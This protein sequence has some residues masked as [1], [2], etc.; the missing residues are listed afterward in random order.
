MFDMHAA[1]RLKESYSAWWKVYDTKTDEPTRQAAREESRLFEMALE[2]VPRFRQSLIH[3]DFS[4][5]E[6][7]KTGLA[8]VNLLVNTV[9]EVIELKFR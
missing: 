5:R 6:L 9:C 1:R 3:G 7:N 4:H 8:L 2:K